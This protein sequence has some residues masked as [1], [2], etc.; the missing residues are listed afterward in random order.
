MARKRKSKHKK[1]I[2]LTAVIA[3]AIF[4]ATGYSILSQNL[5]L[6]GEANLYASKR[7]LWYQ[8]VNNYTSANNGFFH[9][10]QIESGKYSYIGNNNT[11]YIS[12][13]GELWRIVSVEKDHSIKVAKIDNSLITAFDEANNRTENSTYCT[14]LQF[15]CNSWAIQT[16]ITNGEIIGNVENDSTILTYLN[17]TF[18]NSLSD[19]LKNNIIPHS[20]N[21]GPVSPTSTFLEAVVEE[22]EYTWDGYVGLLTLTEMLYPNNNTNITIGESQTNNY[23]LDVA[24]GR[25]IWTAT[26]LKNSSTQVWAINP[27]KT[28]S[29]KDAYLSTETQNDATYNFLA[30]PTFYLKDTVKI[31]SGDGSINAPFTIE[32]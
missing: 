19:D 18:Y 21:I 6:E 25:F 26:P 29:G 23:L 14:N 30:I 28:Q 12:L 20:F 11:N 10:N 24:D 3:V 4:M 7:Y 15:G 17:T 31:A 2:V 9:E 5:K 13:D 32:K 8:I 16:N 27:D 22:Q 1:T